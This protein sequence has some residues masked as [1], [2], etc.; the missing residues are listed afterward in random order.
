MANK[1]QPQGLVPFGKVLSSKVYEAGSTVYPGDIVKMANDGQVDTCA[2][3]AGVACGVALSYATVGNAVLVADSPDQKFIVQADDG[4]VSAQTN[5]GLNYDITVSTADTLY[6]MSRIELDASSG[7]TNSNL[8][9]RALALEGS[10][11]NT[12]GV[13]CDLIVK[14]N[15]HQLGNASEGL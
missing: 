3:G 8:L 2:A 5:I 1:D 11:D 9:L 13:N 7:V 10:I 6:R 14:I 12:F 15:N 4:T